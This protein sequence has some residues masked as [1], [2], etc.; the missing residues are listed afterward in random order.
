MKRKLYCKVLAVGD[1]K[2]EKRFLGHF[3][4]DMFNFKFAFGGRRTDPFFLL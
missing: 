2:S 4:T 1:S 3:Y